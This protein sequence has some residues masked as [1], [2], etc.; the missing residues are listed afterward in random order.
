MIMGADQKVG[1]LNL[2]STHMDVI[3]N[4][5]CEIFQPRYSVVVNSGGYQ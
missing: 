3:G 5:Y 1:H 2:Q 4:A